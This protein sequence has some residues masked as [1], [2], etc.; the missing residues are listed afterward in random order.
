MCF[1]T[2]ALST[3]IRV[4]RTKNKYLD[5]QGTFSQ[6]QNIEQQYNVSRQCMF[7]CT[8]VLERMSHMQLFTCCS[9]FFKVLYSIFQGWCI[10]FANHPGDY[11]TYLLQNKQLATLKEITNKVFQP[12]QITLSSN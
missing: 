8:C 5:T 3:Y 6:I 2:S 7:G 1:S 10:K 11:N 12:Q 9:S 4:F